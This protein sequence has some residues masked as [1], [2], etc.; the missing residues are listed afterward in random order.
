M[1]LVTIFFLL[2]GFFTVSVIF[3][4]P[5][6]QR[7][8]ATNP[9]AVSATSSLI[10]VDLTSKIGSPATATC[11]V[12]AADGSAIAN[13]TC[14]LTASCGTVEPPSG[15]TNENGIAAFLVRSDTACTAQ[16][17]ATVNNS[18]Q[19]TQSASIQFSP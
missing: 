2:F 16:I 15:T 4:G 13:Q 10:V 19:I 18:V 12:R 7:I 6:R 11:I 17:T 5:L 9:P 14:A 3:G 8:R 1:G